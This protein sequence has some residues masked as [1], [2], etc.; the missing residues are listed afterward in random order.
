MLSISN[1]LKACIWNHT[2]TVGH[3]LKE[4]YRPTPG[5]NPK[6]SH[7]RTEEWMSNNHA[8]SNIGVIMCVYAHI[9]V[10]LPVNGTY[11]TEEWIS[12]E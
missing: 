4:E 5:T 1:G 7:K 12:K 2:N 9:K 6:L 8:Y 3:H 11:R 10:N